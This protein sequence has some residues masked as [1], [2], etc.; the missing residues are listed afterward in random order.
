MAEKLELK[1]PVC[2]RTPAEIYEYSPESTGEELTA[3]EYVWKEEG[4][5]D[6]LTGQ[7]LCTSCYIKAGMPVM[8]SGWTATTQNVARELGVE[9]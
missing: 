1:D 3:E 2:G 5:L 9:L 8:S 4:T 6:R 7:F